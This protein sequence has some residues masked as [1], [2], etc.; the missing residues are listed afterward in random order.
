MMAPA[1]VVFVLGGLYTSALVRRPDWRP[2]NLD[3]Y[4]HVFELYGSVLKEVGT[5]VSTCTRTVLS[6]FE[7]QRC[8]KMWGRVSAILRT[9]SIPWVFAG[10]FLL[11]GYEICLGVYR[12]TRKKIQKK[13]IYGLGKVLD[14][15]EIVP[16]RWAW[17]LCMRII[18]VELN[19]EKLNV[20]IPLDMDIPRPGIEVA[21]YQIKNPIRTVY[22]AVPHT[23]HVAVVAGERV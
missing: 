15:P 23:P 7:V 20:M 5:T 10:V 18:R 17:Y 2:A 1:I 11:F 22:T 3:T 12:S 13:E 9:A 8:N 19:K 14:R 4:H 21:V 6:E 16:D